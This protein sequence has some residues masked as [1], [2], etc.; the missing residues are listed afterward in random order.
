MNRLRRSRCW[1]A[2]V[3]GALLVVATAAR[4]AE[5][6]RLLVVTVTTGFRHGSIAT[7]E[8][9]LEQLG[10]ESG[11]F[12]VDFLRLPPGRPGRPPEPKRAPD[13]ADADW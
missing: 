5:P 9:V 1:G 3:V 2:A 11:L 8:P 7:A 4:A 13:T 12:H 10:R 6:A